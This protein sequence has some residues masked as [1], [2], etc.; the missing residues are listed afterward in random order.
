[1]NLRKTQD[2]AIKRATD[3]AASVLEQYGFTVSTNALSLLEES[4]TELIGD[5]PFTQPPITK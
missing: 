4:I 3:A 1:M 5:L 2:A